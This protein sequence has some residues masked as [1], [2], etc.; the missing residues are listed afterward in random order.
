MSETRMD[1]SHLY[2]AIIGLGTR[3]DPSEATRIRRSNGY[4]REALDTYYRRS[5]ACRRVVEIMPRFMCRK[6][7]M[8]TLGGNNNDAKLIDDLQARYSELKVRNKFKLAQTWANLY[9]RCH[10]L[11]ITDDDSFGELSPGD[12]VK[13]LVVLDRWKLYP[14]P[15]MTE[16]SRLNP[17]YYTFLSNDALRT[18]NLYLSAYR[19]MDNVHRSRVLVFTGNNLP[20]SEK[21]RNN[22]CEDSLLEPF[23]DVWK[24]FF[25]SYASLSNIIND[26]D[27]FTH[28][29]DGLF[30]GLMQG[31]AKAKD[32]LYERLE[33]VHVSKSIYGGLVGDLTKEKFEYI[34]RNLGGVGDI[35]DRLQGELVAASGLPK[36]V[37]FGEFAAGLDASG[38]IT[39]EQR[40]LNEL[41]EEAQ[42]D[43]FSDNISELNRLLTAPVKK[44]F[45]WQWKP[46]Y[47]ETAQGN[48]EIRKLYA[49]ID[50][51]NTN[52]GVYTQ[53]EARSRYEAQDFSSEII[54]NRID[55]TDEAGVR[56]STLER[57]QGRVRFRGRLYIPN[58][59]YYAGGQ[60]LVLA[61]KNGFVKLI[62]FG[63]KDVNV[64]AI[65]DN[66][67]LP[68][69]W[70]NLFFSFAQPKEDDISD[71]P[72]YGPACGGNNCKNCARSY[73][74]NRDGTG[75]M[76]CDAFD[77]E[78]KRDYV[79]DDWVG[80]SSMVADDA[81]P[82]KKIIQWQGFS[83]GLQYLPFETRHKKTLLAGYGHFRKTK[84][85]DSMACDVYVGMKLTSPKLFVVEQYI[86][87]E[88]DEDKF[89]IGVDTLEEARN[90]Y[91]S[92]MPKEFLGS[93]REEKIS[94][95][96]SMQCDS[97]IAVGSQ[98]SWKWGTGRGS[99]KVK[100]KHASKI[101]RTIKGVEITRNG[102]PDNPVLEI[103]QENGDMVL[104]LASEVSTTNTDADKFTVSGEV[105]GEDE[106]DAIAEVSEADI[107]DA[108]NNWKQTAPDLYTNILST[109]NDK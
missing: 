49:E 55:H 105:L 17:E 54:L 20:D 45:G 1:S 69:Y 7:G 14:D 30:E 102:T 11:L 100:A 28:Y 74:G 92:A 77:F 73:T 18:T 53:E 103:Q 60:L 38:K 72:N 44:T 16:Y 99:G 13:E 47:T 5:W 78:V 36:S 97:Q 40:Y 62:K 2:N 4:T 31:G 24:R 67:H 79:C 51:I 21:I 65:A 43:K 58:K 80:K 86:N 101:T 104:K 109:N 15:T 57:V 35:A 12:E 34:S 68:V 89:I 42:T 85:A 41:V 64:N 19:T 81:T 88:F 106:F 83:V 3:R 6:W 29:I 50:E 33:T 93:I 9:G 84:G 91:L 26:F 76:N 52:I 61:T 46:L 22:A 95:L 59:P 10:I 70:A 90:I 56:L 66:P 107:I 48:A 37:L 39:G 75:W 63:E 82:V 27:I 96:Q 98:V 71:A 32:D 94:Y 8:P 23:I 108:V 25:T 87:G